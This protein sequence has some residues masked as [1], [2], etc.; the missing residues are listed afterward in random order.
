MPQ[1]QFDTV[2]R[3]QA[4]GQKDSTEYVTVT[5]GTESRGKLIENC[6]EINWPLA[7]LL[8]LTPQY[9]YGSFAMAT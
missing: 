8:Q 9:F 5:V 3:S 6:Y 7:A 4:D 1:I 2:T